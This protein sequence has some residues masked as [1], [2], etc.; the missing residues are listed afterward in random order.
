MIDKIFILDRLKAIG[1]HFVFS[2]VLGI[3]ALYLVFFLWY[4]YPLNIAMGVTKIYLTMLFI[5]VFLGPIF[6][7][8]IF[9]ENKKK[10]IIDLS[11]ILIL[12][13]TAYGYG[14]YT[15]SI[16]R[17]AWLVFVVDDIE[18]VSPI[19][20]HS[21]DKNNINKNLLAPPEWIAATY[22]KN[23]KIAAQQKED[24]IFKGISLA[25]RL[26]VF[27]P[28]TTRS[29]DILKKVKSLKQLNEFNSQDQILKELK[30]YNTA[31]GWLPVKAPQ[32]D[33]VALFDAHGQ[34]LG[35]ANLR[36]WN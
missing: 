28:I 24:E 2:I 33:M 30:N 6:T 29:D 8:I 19:D 22:S 14:L 4:P 25:T 36:P 16:G 20:V 32:Y 35:V 31:T 17:A 26:E 27:H 15:M 10:F 5:D 18:V 23:P 21:N 13:L 9:K 1:C 3:V 34:P 11:F 7:G 12:Q